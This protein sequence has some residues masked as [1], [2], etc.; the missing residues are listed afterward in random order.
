M[1]L[2]LRHDFKGLVNS[3]ERAPEAT[4]K[5]VHVQL[6]MAVRDIRERAAEH[7]HYISRSGMLE[8][9]GVISQVADN[10]G[11]VELNPAVPYAAYVH[12]G[13]KPHLIIPKS[14]NVLRFV[15]N[16]DYVFSKRV[17]HPGTQKDQF[18]YNAAEHQ[19]PEIQSRFEHALEE[20]LKRV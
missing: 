4:K 20:L 1:E 6:K 2:K 17:K 19:L 11:I 15:A 9:E 10:K 18:L 3:F 12:E 8:R 7:H 5:M 13:T 14:C 16:G